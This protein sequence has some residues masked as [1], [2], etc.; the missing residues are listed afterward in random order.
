M[1]IDAKTVREYYLRPEILERMFEVAEG[2]EVVPVFAGGMYGKRP[3]S[4][5]F[6]GDFEYMAKK[7]ATSFHCS[8]EH[9]TNPLLL[10]N[11]M[12]QA[13][14]EKIRT[15]WDLILDIDANDD[16][17]HGK[18]AARLIIDALG[19]HGI[20]NLSLKFSGRR[21]FHIG[22][23]CKSLPD[24]INFRPVKALYP[25]LMQKVADYLRDYIREKLVTALANYDKTLDSR[26]CGDPYKILEVEHNW[27]VRH[28]FR[29]PYSFNEKAGRVSL[30]L[31]PSKLSDFKIDDALPQ[32]VKGDM[33]FLQKYKEDEALDLFMEA[34]D[35][36]SGDGKKE[37]KPARWMEKIGEHM[38][39]DG[40]FIRNTKEK[41]TRDGIVLDHISSRVV[42]DKSEIEEMIRG[43]EKMKAERKYSAP[44][45]ISEDL[46]PACIQN[47]FKGL[48]DGRKRSI[49]IIINFLRSAGW[50]MDEIDEK[51]KEW[52]TNNPEPLSES[53][54][55]GQVSHARKSPP[56]LPPNCS[57]E[58]YYKDILICTPDN[59]CARFKNPIT[60]A[61]YR[62]KESKGKDKG[63]SKGKGLKNKKASDDVVIPD[64]KG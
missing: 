59:L 39:A 10:S 60:Y 55:Q 26:M 46:F 50:S 43:S 62:A 54:I 25:E 13:D 19:A 52:N 20:K 53:Y 16:L 35:H 44:G 24:K 56:F 45:K 7:G 30:P 4:V 32:N 61:L 47:I 40:L 8:V 48:K 23:P 1:D 58:G 41:M 38:R 14:I 36:T 31:D 15:G 51:L 28:L 9:W 22:V 63:K 57:N 21:G 33:G 3:S 49:F 18:I 42:F 27:S 2:R 17:E 29:M 12:K 64:G 6:P 37:K 5:Q 34:M 11:T